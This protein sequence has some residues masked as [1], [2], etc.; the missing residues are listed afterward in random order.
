[1]TGVT[2]DHPR[3][4][5]PIIRSA[6]LYKSINHNLQVKW[7]AHSLE[8]FET[9]SIQKLSEE[10]DLIIFDHPFIGEVVKNN[11]LFVISDFLDQNQLQFLEDEILGNSL[12]SYKANGRLW[13]LPVDGASQMSAYL[14][15]QNK[16]YEFANASIE[17]L[18]KTSLDKDFAQSTAFP[19]V[20]TH[21]SCTFLSLAH[22]LNQES[23]TGLFFLTNSIFTE[24]L[25]LLKQLAKTFNP[26]SFEVNPIQLLDLMSEDKEIKYSPFVFGYSP[27]SVSGFRANK[28]KFA[29]SPGFGGNHSRTILGGAGLGVSKMCKNPEAAAAYAYWLTTKKIQAEIFPV[30]LGQPASKSGWQ[31]N[32]NPEMFENFF[33]SSYSSIENAFVRPR[34]SGW[35]KFQETFGEILISAIKD[36]IT[37]EDALDEIKREMSVNCDMSQSNLFDISDTN[38]EMLGAEL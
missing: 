1:M 15:N 6:E 19:M 34:M 8:D 11:S 13:A 31:S 36:Q 28:I 24:S 37:A 26:I 21:A 33:E 27:Y 29:P 30:N 20:P 16:T 17:N 3:A 38:I 18:I 14:E 4:T 12:H 10:F 7:T 2:F 35:P 9:Q 22:T 25:L 32:S 5:Q 23:S